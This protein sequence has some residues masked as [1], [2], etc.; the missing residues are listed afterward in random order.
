MIKIS[1]GGRSALKWT[2]PLFGV[3]GLAMV[4]ATSHHG[5][6]DEFKK[7]DQGQKI[8]DSLFE[9]FQSAVTNN[10]D[11]ILIGEIYLVP[12]GVEG[13]VDCIVSYQDSPKFEIKP[14]SV[15][16]FM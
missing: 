15:V 16:P 4:F 12:I 2:A 5:T 13:K 6:C 1:K 14:L 3:A 10:A 11:A 8:V 9:E 7:S